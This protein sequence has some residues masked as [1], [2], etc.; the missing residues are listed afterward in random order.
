MIKFVFRQN[1]KYPL[2]LLIWN[3][4]RDIE[5]YLISY[6][7]SFE[8]SLIYTPLM[9]LGEFSTG[10]II[11]Q[12]QKKFLTKNKTNEKTKISFPVLIREK[13]RPTI[14]TLDSKAKIL[15]IIFYGAF[16]DF[17]QFVLSLY[18]SKFINIS[19]S[20]ETR[21][22]GIF[23]INN[24]LFYYYILK[25]PI[26]SHQKLSLIIIGICLVFIIFT[27]FIFQEINIFLT[28]WLFAAFLILTFIILFVSA[29]VESYEK[30]LFEYDNL[31]PFYILKYE[32]IFGFFLTFI[33][34]LF[35]SPFDDIIKF[36]KNQ[37]SLDLFILIFA[38]ILYI[39]LSGLKNSY[40]LLTTKIY[41]P[42]VATFM[43]YI[44]NPLVLIYNF[45]FDDDF[46]PY[47]KRNYAYFI[48]N[49]IISVIVTFCGCIYNEFFII[50]CYN[51][52][53]DTHDQITTRS[54]VETELS[55]IYDIND[56]DNNNDEN[57]QNNAESIYI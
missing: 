49:L 23:T 28:Y 31:D 45:I 43:D 1:L 13:K 51:L 33:Y 21:L 46:T 40:R 30:Y 27:E 41:S 17:L 39:I 20:I 4:L 37:S 7:Y 24:A 52:E 5:C 9:F 14:H 47:G 44:L 26:F 55:S 12:Y 29:Q 50:F 19:V 53:R 18:T 2:Q 54:I 34:S 42:M 22:R 10:L 15:Y 11:N 35:H 48:I 32:G 3:I 8:D 36:Q 6:F 56:E 38:L 16:C 57:I 25:L